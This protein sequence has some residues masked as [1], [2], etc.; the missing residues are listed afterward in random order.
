MRMG[1]VLVRSFF[2][3]HAAP[4]H[5]TAKRQTMR[6]TQAARLEPRQLGPQFPQLPPLTGRGLR[7]NPRALTPRLA[8]QKIQ[9][10][11]I[12]ASPLFFCRG[13][14]G[15]AN[16]PEYWG[17]GRGVA[18]AGWGAPLKPRP[19]LTPFP[20]TLAR[21]YRVSLSFQVFL[22][23]SLPS[24]VGA[25]MVPGAVLRPTPDTMRAHTPSA[26]CVGSRWVLT[27]CD[28]LMRGHPAAP[29]GRLAPRARALPPTH[30]AAGF[31]GESPRYRCGTLSYARACVPAL[32]RGSRSFRF[33]R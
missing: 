19:P 16:M 13:V 3:A 26:P 23:G 31:C 22:V 29:L 15:L 25:R 33:P 21:G 27:V 8:P 18:P 32:R 10:S 17:A 1:I 30:F 20:P 6:Q 9:H 2:I 4:T 14:A 12:L 28:V 7:E 11:G 5:Q 24:G